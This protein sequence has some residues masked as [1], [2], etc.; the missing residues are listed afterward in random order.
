MCLC[1]FAM[2]WWRSRVRRVRRG[3]TQAA[4]ARKQRES[5]SR[6]YRQQPV[7]SFQNGT[8]PATLRS[9]TTTDEH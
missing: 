4:D 6:G 9:W 1:A 5:A 8:A 2:R 7:V 3:T